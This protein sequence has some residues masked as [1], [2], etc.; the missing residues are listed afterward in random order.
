MA[1]ELNANP[2]RLDMDWRWIR[3]A[4]DKGVLISINPDAHSVEGIADMSYGVA[5]ARKGRLLN[6]QCLNTMDIEEFQEWMTEQHEK[7][8]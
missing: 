2:N 5:S 6:H 7:R 8:G 3:Q 4:T 1:I